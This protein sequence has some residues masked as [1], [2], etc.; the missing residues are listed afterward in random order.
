MKFGTSK[1]F[2]SFEPVRY[3]KDENFQPT[4]KVLSYN[5]LYVM[6]L[7][8]LI[9]PR[10]SIFTISQTLLLIGL[11][12]SL[13][14]VLAVSAC[15]LPQS[16]G[17]LIPA[18]PDGKYCLSLSFPMA[19]NLT[20]ITLCSFVIALFSNLMLN[21]WWLLR[22][23]LQTVLSFC[24]DI[25]SKITSCVVVKVRHASPE[26]REVVLNEAEA[27][28][29]TIAGLLTLSLFKLFARARY[30]LQFSP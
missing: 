27:F 21:R 30:G 13:A 14:T 5:E 26:N 8:W 17:D 25:L 6:T 4:G 22:T 11:F 20:L 1:R 28:C 29:Y 2:Y 3:E 7:G 12:C 23:N 24:Y 10:G 9:P 18:I 16:N 15:P 19:S